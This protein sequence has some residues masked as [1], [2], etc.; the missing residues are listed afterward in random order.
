MWRR[1]WQGWG[2][3]L[4]VAVTL[5]MAIRAGVAEARVVPTQSMVPTIQPGDRLLT[6][7]L[8]WRFTGLDR[9]DIVVFTPPFKGEDYLKRVI[10]L[11]GETV[12]VRNGQVRVNG[13]ALSEPYI[14]ERPRY[15]YGPVAVPRG[16]VLVLGDNRNN[17]YDSHEWGLLDIKAVQGRAVLRIW[18]L[19]RMG[20][21]A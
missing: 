3:E 17:S 16:K 7:K 2:K 15:T 5:A 14:K 6:E 4:L 12:E 19:Q 9:G 21:L 11:P 18:P 1:F 20:A 13:V 8:V 10:G